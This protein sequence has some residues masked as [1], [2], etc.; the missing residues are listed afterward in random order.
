[1]LF[2]ASQR[3]YMQKI[4]FIKNHDGHRIGN[5]I[6]VSNNVAHGLIDR[7]IAV[8]SGYRSSAFFGP[9]EDKMMR[10]KRKIQKRRTEKIRKR[11]QTFETK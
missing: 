7:G 10:P 3:I 4:T 9:P 1:M 11:K 6:S 5:T 2:P 8:L